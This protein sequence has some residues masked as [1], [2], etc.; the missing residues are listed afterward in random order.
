MMSF[1]PPYREFL[2]GSIPGQL[3]HANLQSSSMKLGF[4]LHSPA[5]TVALPLPGLGG[6]Q[7]GSTDRESVIQSIETFDFFSTQ[8]LWRR[9]AF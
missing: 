2:P 1:P 9:H 8:R 6:C 3:L 5:F 4:F 7:I